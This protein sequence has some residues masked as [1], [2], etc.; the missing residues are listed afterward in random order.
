MLKTCRRDFCCKVNVEP[1]LYEYLGSHKDNLPIWMTTKEIFKANF[2][3]DRDYKPIVSV[4]EIKHMAE[5]E[6]AKS[7]YERSNKVRI[8]L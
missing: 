8:L 5:L 2:E 1:G 4:E 3:I 6:T 7:Y